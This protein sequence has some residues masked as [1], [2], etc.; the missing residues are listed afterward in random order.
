MNKY[1]ETILMSN[2]I[3]NTLSKIVEELRNIANEDNYST[4]REDA[5]VRELVDY[6]RESL[7]VMPKI[8]DTYRDLKYRD[9]NIT[10]DDDREYIKLEE[11]YNTLDSV[12]NSENAYASLTD[13]VNWTK[14]GKYEEDSE[15]AFRSVKELIISKICRLADIVYKYNRSMIVSNLLEDENGGYRKLINLTYDLSK[16]VEIEDITSLFNVVHTLPGLTSEDQKAMIRSTLGLVDGSLPLSRK[17]NMSEIDVLRIQTL[18]N[19][20]LAGNL[21]YAVDFVL[22]TIDK[23]IELIS[24]VAKNLEIVAAN[25]IITLDS[26]MS[27]LYPRLYPRSIHILNGGLQ[28]STDFTNEIMESL[29][30]SNVLKNGMIKEYSDFAIFEPHFVNYN[31]ISNN[32]TASMNEVVKAADLD[33]IYKLFVSSCLALVSAAGN[34]LSSSNKSKAIDRTMDID[35]VVKSYSTIHDLIFDKIFTKTEDDNYLVSESEILKDSLNNMIFRKGLMNRA[36][37]KLV[38][39]MLQPFKDEEQSSKNS[40]VIAHRIVSQL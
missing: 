1:I 28:L 15:F 2:K 22:N 9:L 24:T 11:C 38:D 32:G 23:D 25:T 10:E 13:G 26:E 5:L 31:L 14:Y 16:T 29:K 36:S 4:E 20:K 19:F 18:S 35:E 21:T 17:M 6:S 40:I 7:K 33:N 27:D 12:L 30:D 8:I 34:L 37:A 39:V 3:V